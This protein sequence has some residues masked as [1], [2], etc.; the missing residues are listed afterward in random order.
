MAARTRQGRTHQQ[1]RTAAR[2]LCVRPVDSGPKLSDVVRFQLGRRIPC[3]SRALASVA[4]NDTIASSRHRATGA[5]GAHVLVRPQVTRLPKETLCWSIRSRPRH[6]SSAT[7]ANTTPQDG[8]FNAQDLHPGGL[9]VA[10]N[11]MVAR[12]LRSATQKRVQLVAER[13]RHAQ[14]SSCDGLSAERRMKRTAAGQEVEHR[15]CT[16]CDDEPGSL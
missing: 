5:G 4:T 10:S 3:W 14:Q 7:P 8:A 12:G 11:A 16:P 1:P 9:S 6:S 13:I 2:S 15:S